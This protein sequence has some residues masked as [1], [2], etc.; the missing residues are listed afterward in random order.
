M[1]SLASARGKKEGEGVV[2]EHLD[3][4]HDAGGPGTRCVNPHPLSVSL[5]IGVHV[6]QRAYR[7]FLQKVW[8]K[9]RVVPQ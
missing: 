1:P 3:V 6:V 8:N 2:G 4:W 7:V 5:S 9:N